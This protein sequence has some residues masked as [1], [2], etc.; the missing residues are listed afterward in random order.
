MSGRSV[1]PAIKTKMK[2]KR[3]PAAPEREGH[4]AFVA[5]IGRLVRLARAKRGMTRRQLAQASGASERYLAQ[6]EG[7]EG[8]PSVII[9][10]SIARALDVPIVELLPRSNGRTPAM[11]NILDILGRVPLAELPALAELIESRAGQ[12]AAVDR[13]RRIALIGLRGA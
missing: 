12:G 11:A 1:V 13:A 9:L 2:A 8:N 7:G 5:A 10:A 3:S 4:R 6:I